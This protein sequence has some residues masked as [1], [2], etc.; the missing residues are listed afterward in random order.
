MQILVNN[1]LN[2]IY[3]Y[4]ILKLILTNIKSRQKQNNFPFLQGG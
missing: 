3:K 4:K 2:I 1:L